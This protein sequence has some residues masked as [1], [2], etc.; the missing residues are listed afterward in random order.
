M[1]KQNKLNCKVG[2]RK[3]AIKDEVFK[4]EIVLCKKLAKENNGKCC[5]G[6]CKTCGVVPLL[7]KLNKGELLEDPKQIAKVKNKLLVDL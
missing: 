3:G 5:W 2:L 7:Y 4:R 1:K 6:K